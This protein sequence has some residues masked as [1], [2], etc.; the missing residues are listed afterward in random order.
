MSNKFIIKDIR[1]SIIIMK[2]YNMKL[3]MFGYRKALMLN[4]IIDMTAH[5]IFM[6]SNY[7]LLLNGFISCFSCLLTFP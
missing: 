1:K 3:I 2:L 7:V 4:I 5:M 6:R